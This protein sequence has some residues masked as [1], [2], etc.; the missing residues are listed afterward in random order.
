VQL[1][2]LSGPDQGRAFPIG[3]LPALIGRGADVAVPLDGDITVSRRHAE[4]YAPQGA[5]RI[6]DLGSSHGTQVNGF[7]IQDKSLEMGDRI[8]VGKTL[9][10]VES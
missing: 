1:R 3:R 8:Q 7:S 10:Q 4:I 6:R 5:L 2:V 9:L